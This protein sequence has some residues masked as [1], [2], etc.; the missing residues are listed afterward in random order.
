MERVLGGEVLLSL[1][2]LSEEVELSRGLK[3]AF[4]LCTN[5]FQEPCIAL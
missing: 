3:E 2:E 5:L 4:S 1:R